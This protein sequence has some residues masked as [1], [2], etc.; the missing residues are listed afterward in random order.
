MIKYFTP[1]ESKDIPQNQKLNKSIQQTGCQ[2]SKLTMNFV[3][4]YA[5]A[6]KV[7]KTNSLGNMNILLN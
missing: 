5:A 6:L 7:I 4:G 3:L 1:E 2:P